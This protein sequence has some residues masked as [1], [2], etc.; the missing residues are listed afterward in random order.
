[1]HIVGEDIVLY[2]QGPYNKRHNP[3]VDRSLLFLFA[4]GVDQPLHAFYFFMY[5]PT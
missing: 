2:H 3:F 1:M 4:T 5:I